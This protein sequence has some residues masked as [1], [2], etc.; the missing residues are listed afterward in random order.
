[1]NL[2]RLQAFCASLPQSA[3]DVKWGADL[4]FLIDTK[5]FT[6]FA[7]HDGKPANVCFKCD[8]ERFL[9]LTDQP[10]IVPAPYLARAH[11]VLVEKTGALTDAQAQAL[12]RRS[13]ELIVAK[14]P[15]RRQR[16]LL[17]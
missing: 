13:Y 16:E 4:C 6:V 7:I 12:V 3:H 8:P 14:L 2:V 9:E 1:M 5:M 15:K 17:P 10:G 11:W